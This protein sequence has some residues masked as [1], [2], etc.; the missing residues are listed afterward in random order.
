[1]VKLS[2]CSQTLDSFT[3]LLTSFIFP[4]VLLCDSKFSQ[5]DC[6]KLLFL[7]FCFCIIL[8]QSCTLVKLAEKSSRICKPLN[9]PGRGLLSEWKVCGQVQNHKRKIS[10]LCDCKGDVL[11][12]IVLGSFYNRIFVTCAKDN[13]VMG[14]LTSIFS[15]EVAFITLSTLIS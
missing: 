14:C 9:V 11:I 12:E 15:P 3:R 7:P 5:A 13:F 2:L 10:N 6:N 8:L 4:D 1:M